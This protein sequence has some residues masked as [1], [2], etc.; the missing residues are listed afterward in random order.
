MV[1]IICVVKEKILHNI[2]VVQPV[3]GHIVVVVS[4]NVTEMA[5]VVKY[6]LRIKKH[7][8]FL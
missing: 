1:H 8:K 4:T 5:V 7:I 2:N 6:A 3:L